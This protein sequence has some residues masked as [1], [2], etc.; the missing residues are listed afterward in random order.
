VRLRV[1]EGIILAFFLYTAGI[2]PFFPDR[3]PGIQPILTLC[4][5]VITLFLVARGATASRSEPGLPARARIFDHA[6]DWLPI[7]YTLLAFREMELFVPAV[8]NQSFERSWMHLDAAILPWLRA[9]PAAS[10]LEFCYLLVYGLPAY[11][12]W[13]LYKQQ[14]RPACDYFW[15]LYLA[16]TLTAYALFPYFPSRPPRIAFPQSF[17]PPANALHRF[18]V[19]LL[20]NATIH[21]GVFPSA[22]VSS[23]FAAAWALLLIF[24]KRK[25]FGYIALAYAI[26]VAVATV[27]GRY[28]YAADVISGVFVS[29]TGV[30]I[31]CC[32]RLRKAGGAG[33]T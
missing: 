19:A 26:S 21:T 22:H 6:R 15:S 3:H 24:P 10:Y 20:N 16:G 31:S 8:Y 28:H 1:S 11:C 9:S 29:F 18:N 32:G 4:A 2:A 25:R 33:A 30:L 5:V 23:A 27:F 17:P 13:L 12:L 14:R 7:G